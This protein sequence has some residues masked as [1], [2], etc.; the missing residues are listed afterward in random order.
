MELSKAFDWIPHDLLV[1]KLHA[2][3]FTMNAIAFIYSYMTRREQGVKMIDTGS[4]FKILLSGVPPS[5][6]HPKSDLVQHIH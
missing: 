2:Y 3:G 1:A 6:I 5:R 4:L